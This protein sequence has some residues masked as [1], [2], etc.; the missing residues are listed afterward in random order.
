MD[1]G[2]CRRSD[3]VAFLLHF[4]DFPG[5]LGRS[6]FD[7]FRGRPCFAPGRHLGAQSARKGAKREPK[8]MKKEVRTHLQEHAKTMA[9]TVREAYGEVPGRVRAT[10]SSERGAKASTEGSREGS[11]RIFHDFRSPLGAP[12]GTILEEKGPLEID[13]NKQPCKQT[14]KHKHVTNFEVNMLPARLMC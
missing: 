7:V 10:L 6:I 8:V 2:S 11:R 3:F 4:G 14:Q 13:T 9:G 5:L 12:W 1:F